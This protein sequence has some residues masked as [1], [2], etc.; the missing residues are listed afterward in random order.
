M[1]QNEKNRPADVR[2]V[3]EYLRVLAGAYP[4]IPLLSV[5]GIYGPETTEAVEAF[6]TLF[7]L[8][9]TGEVD[10][11]IW[12]CLREEYRRLVYPTTLPRGIYPFKAGEP[13]LQLGDSGATVTL[14]QVMLD[15]VA[16]HYENLHRVPP[17][18]QF[19]AVTERA[20]RQAQQVFGFLPH[21]QLDRRT[22]DRLA[23]TYN[24]YVAR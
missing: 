22:W 3:Q 8:P 14:L 7:A 18:G 10:G 13:F 17:S 19:D 23:H 5:D 20:V 21:G 16:L 15:T 24:T 4:R 1:T 12:A 9:V 6:Q 11:E 2:E